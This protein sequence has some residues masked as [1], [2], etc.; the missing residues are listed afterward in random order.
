MR[1]GRA[2]GLLRLLATAKQ[3]YATASAARHGHA[4][5]SWF[6]HA[7]TARLSS[8]WTT[9]SETSSWSMALTDHF[10]LPL[11]TRESVP[12]SVMLKTLVRRS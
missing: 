10:D 1:V 8:N 9:L 5:R 2:S 7:E 6:G 12:L 11:V 3:V 4:S